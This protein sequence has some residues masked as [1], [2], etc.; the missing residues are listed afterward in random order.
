MYRRIPVFLLLILLSS[1]EWFLRPHGYDYPYGDL[2]DHPVNL[3][4]FNT[5]FDDYNSTAPTLGWLI[6]FCFSTNRNSQGSELDVIY[7]PMDVRWSKDDGELTVSNEYGGWGI[8][9]EEYQSL[10]Q[11]VRKI[12]SDGNELGPNLVVDTTFD[13]F[14]LTLLYANDTAGDFDIFFISDFNDASFSEPEAVGFLNSDYD[15]LYPAF[16]PGRDRVYFCSDRENENFDIYYS[17]IPGSKTRL[18]SL[19][20]DTTH[21]RILKESVLSGDSNDKCPHIFGNMVVLASDREGGYGGFDLYYSIFD[22]GSWGNP[23]NFGPV[24]NTEADEYRPILI[25][26]GVTEEKI[27]MVW[28]SNRDDGLGGFDL[29]FTGIPVEN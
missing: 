28:S 10:V 22:K 4:A 17:E 2:P 7:Q 13:G 25:N 18:D 16:S 9:A 24:I 29:W 11:G 14:Q 26:E 23:V 5:E 6:P 15:D 8:Y 19:L 20:M 21:H 27:M 12:R 1:C 3:E